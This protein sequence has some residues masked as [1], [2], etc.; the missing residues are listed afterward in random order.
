MRPNVRSKANRKIAKIVLHFP[1]LEFAKT[2]V[3]N[4]LNQSRCSAWVTPCNRRVHR[5]VLL[6]TPPRL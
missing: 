5:L 1:D 6:G 3:L 4:S 2:A